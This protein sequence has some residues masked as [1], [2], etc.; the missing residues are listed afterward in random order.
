MVSPTVT[1]GQAIHAG[2][3]IISVDGG[4]TR[5]PL[6]TVLVTLKLDQRGAYR[7]SLLVERT[8]R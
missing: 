2:L 3:R 5:G 8:A 7:R 1:S 6:N 4:E